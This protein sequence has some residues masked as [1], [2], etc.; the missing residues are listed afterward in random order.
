MSALRLWAVAAF[1]VA[2]LIFVNAGAVDAAAKKNSLEDQ[3]KKLDT[4]NDGKLSKDEFAKMGKGAKANAANNKKTDKLF[5]KLDTNNDGFLSLD[6][7]KKIADM[8]KK[9]NNQ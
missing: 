2:A 4:N 3:F 1:G 6:E 8:K 5:Q 7:F 9:K